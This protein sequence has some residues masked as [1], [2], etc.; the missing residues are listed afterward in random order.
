[1]NITTALKALPVLG[2]AGANVTLPHKQTA[3]A[4]MDEISEV[5]RRIGAINTVI[6]GS[7]GQLMGD[8][9]D[10]Y[11]FIENL[12]QQAPQWQPRS[13]A[14]L[15]LGAGG[16][17][18]AICVALQDAGVPKI[19][20]ANRTAANAEAIASGL[21]GFCEVVP[22]S[23]RH[24][25]LADMSLFVNSTT[26]GMINAPPLELDLTALPLSAVVSDIVYNPLATPLLVAARHRGNVGVDG[27]GMLLHQARPGFRAWFGAD[28]EVTAA[29]RSAVLAD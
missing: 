27:L 2:L 3:L 11:G 7:Q 15:V 10:A 17:S 1:E 14:A 26:L 24:L 25:A 29:L 9:T 20:L 6:V 28:P 13:G 12:R 5:A 16:A 22:W 4:V 23:K 21:K 8:N 19:Y 18:R